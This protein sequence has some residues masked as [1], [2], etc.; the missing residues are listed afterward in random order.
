MLLHI[1]L[2]YVLC[3]DNICS[4]KILLR[5][6]NYIFYRK[7]SIKYNSMN[8]FVRLLSIDSNENENKYNEKLNMIFYLLKYKQNK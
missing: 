5:I 3:S 1:T 7:Y 6:N 8:R 2:Y 4:V